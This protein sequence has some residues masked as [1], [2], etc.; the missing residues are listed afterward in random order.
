MLLSE[1]TKT[2]YYRLVSPTLWQQQLPKIGAL[3]FK[4]LPGSHEKEL[5]I[6][7]NGYFSYRREDAFKY[8]GSAPEMEKEAKTIANTFLQEKGKKVSE[9][10]AEKNIALPAIFPNSLYFVKATASYDKVGDTSKLNHWC[11]EYGLR[12]PVLKWDKNTPALVASVLAEY[13]SP[14]AQ[15][16]DK[17][18]ALKDLVNK[19]LY[20]PV[21]NASLKLYIGAKQKVIGMDYAF[22][23]LETQPT[24]TALLNAPDRTRL[25]GLQAVEDVPALPDFMFRE[26]NGLVVPFY[27]DGVAACREGVVKSLISNELFNDNYPIVANTGTYIII[28][29]HGCF[30]TKTADKRFKDIGQNVGGILVDKFS[31][32][33]FVTYIADNNITAFIVMQ[34]TEYNL[35]IKNIVINEKLPGGKLKFTPEQLAYQNTSKTATIRKKYITI[36]QETWGNIFLNESKST[37]SMEEHCG[38]LVRDKIEGKISTKFY[39]T[40]G[41]MNSELEVEPAYLKRERITDSDGNGSEITVVNWEYLEKTTGLSETDFQNRGIVAIHSHHVGGE[42]PSPADIDNYNGIDPLLA[43]STKSWWHMV[44]GTPKKDSK[45]KILYIAYGVLNTSVQPSTYLFN[46]TTQLLVLSYYDISKYIFNT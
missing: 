23:L 5:H 13:E 29:Q 40:T 17:T 26:V 19:H 37:A 4:D 46:Q 16:E 41:E 27:I 39:D 2:L 9:Y 30:M 35:E 28:P 34:P 45:E 31:D 36:D 32:L 7:E 24:P 25:S 1:Y 8:A 43:V 20:A 6:S 42:P 21:E 38:I 14:F 10:F 22:P 44:T 11:V 12:L 15:T 3:L 18:A 33:P